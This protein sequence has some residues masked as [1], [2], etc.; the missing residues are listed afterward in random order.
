MIK[1]LRLL[2]ISLPEIGPI[3]IHYI[4]MVIMLKIY[5]N[6]TDKSHR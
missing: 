2:H 6:G 5:F 3:I 1:A 4:E